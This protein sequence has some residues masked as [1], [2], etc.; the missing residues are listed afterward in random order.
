MALSVERYHWGFTVT[1]L[2]SHGTD[3]W[4]DTLKFSGYYCDEDDCLDDGSCHPGKY[5]ENLAKEVWL[6]T[7]RE[8]GYQHQSPMKGGDW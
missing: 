2:V 1:G 5:W 7:A 6:K 8:K 4:Y 3:K